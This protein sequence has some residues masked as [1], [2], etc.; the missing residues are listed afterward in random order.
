M[1]ILKDRICFGIDIRKKLSGSDLYVKTFQLASILPV[2]Y[3][4]MASGYMAIF[5]KNTIFSV[6]FDIGVSVLPR[7]ETMALSYVYHSNDNEVTVVFAMMVI[8]LI[9]GLLSD[10]IFRENEKRGIAARK[11]FIALIALDLVI[12]LLPMKFNLAFGLPMAVIGFIVR[13]GF[14]VLLL[15][16]LKAVKNKEVKS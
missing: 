2:V 9:L 13:A 3:L 1:N 8:G 4:F 12:R 5:S 7:V 14:I 6:L 15:M 10:K 11:V 16:D